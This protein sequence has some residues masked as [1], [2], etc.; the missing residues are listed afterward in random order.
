MPNDGQGNG[1]GEGFALTTLP[2]RAEIS[3]AQLEEW[4]KLYGKSVRQIRRWLAEGEKVGDPCPLDNPSALP[5]WWTKHKT[6]SVPAIFLQLAKGAGG[7]ET[8]KP[9]PLAAPVDLSTLDLADGEAVEQAR[10][11]VKGAWNE[12][13]RAFSDGRPVD[14]LLTRHAKAMETLRKQEKDAQEAAKRRG[15]WLPKAKLEADVEKA[16]RM[17]KQMRDSMERKV[18]EQLPGVSPELKAQ[19]GR[20]IRGIREKEDF[21]FRNLRKVKSEEDVADLLAA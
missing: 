2:R 19:I 10:R 13:E 14:H 18:L 17:L 16:L 9:E 1:P 12:V 21:V 4:A 11:L 6:W 7:A 5:D 20:A 15:D 8:G 3:C